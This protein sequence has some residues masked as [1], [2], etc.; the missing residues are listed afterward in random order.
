MMNQIIF[1]AT[2]FCLTDS[3]VTWPQLYR[4]LRVSSYLSKTKQTKIKI[5]TKTYLFTRETEIEKDKET[6][7]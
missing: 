2:W 7:G 5:T 6:K 3:Q 4:T 1:T